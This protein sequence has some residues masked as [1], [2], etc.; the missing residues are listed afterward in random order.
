MTEDEHEAQRKLVRPGAPAVPAPPVV[1]AASVEPAAQTKVVAPSPAA[2]STPLVPAAPAVPAAPLVPTTPALPAAY[3]PQ[4]KVVPSTGA[5]TPVIP[6]ASAIPTAPA[7]ESDSDADGEPDPDADSDEESEE[8]VPLTTADRLR[9]LSPAPVILTAGSI[10]S[11]AFLAL[12]VTSHTTPLP[13][14]MSAAVVTGL[15][16]GVDAAIASVSTW[17]SGQ[18]GDSGRAL[19]LAVVGGV[20]ALVAAGAFAGTLV[21][22]LVLNS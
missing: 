18:D 3:Q 1:P 4:T 5:L 17:R 21:M 2:S 14:L 15:I 10:G 12:A 20:A 19:L 11:L 9:R 13:V 8:D 22:I 6:T 7:I 16:F